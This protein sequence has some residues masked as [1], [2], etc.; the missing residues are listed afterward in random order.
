MSQKIYDATKT[1]RHVGF[2]KI[3]QL[4]FSSLFNLVSCVLVAEKGFSEQAQD[5]M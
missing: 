1:P 5:C 4:T 3:I 2:T